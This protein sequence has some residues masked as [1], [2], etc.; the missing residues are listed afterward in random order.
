MHLTKI[1]LVNSFHHCTLLLF[2]TYD[3]LKQ[4]PLIVFSNRL[5]L[6]VSDN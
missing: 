1:Q 4:F 5:A 6:M 2:Q 3:K